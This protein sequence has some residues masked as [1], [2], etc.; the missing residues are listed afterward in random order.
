MSTI[1]EKVAKIAKD[2]PLVKQTGAG[3][4]FSL[5]KRMKAE[6]EMNIPVHRRT[7]AMLATSGAKKATVITAHE[8]E[9]LYSKMTHQLKREYPE[10]AAR[11]LNEDDADDEREFRRF[12][13]MSKD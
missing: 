1:D 8:W 6:Q 5:V 3:R 10:L 4:L 7:T 13:G 9:Q 11:A 2:H 12:H